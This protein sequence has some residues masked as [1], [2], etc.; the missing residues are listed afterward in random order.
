MQMRT[1][2]TAG[3]ASQANHFT[4]FHILVFTDQLLGQVSVYRFQAIVVT[5]NDV[6]TI[7][8]TATLVLHH[9]HLTIEGRTNR[10]TDVNLHIDTLV[11]TA[12]TRTEL[13]SNLGIGCR[14]AIA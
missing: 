2:R 1:G 7:S 4:R 11:H 9:T 5:D 13:G 6:L 8:C 10:V 12:A 3:I 14:H